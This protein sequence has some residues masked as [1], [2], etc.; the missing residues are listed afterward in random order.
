[1]IGFYVHF[2]RGACGQTIL[3]DIVKNNIS[4]FAVLVM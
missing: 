1:M 2:H 3:N 4:P